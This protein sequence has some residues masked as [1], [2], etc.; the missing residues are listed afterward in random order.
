MA[1]SL[2]VLHVDDDQDFLELLKQLLEK[3][4][5]GISITSVPNPAL[6]LQLLEDGKF[7]AVISDYQMREMT[8]LELLEKLR[9][10]GS[11]IPFIMLTGKGR[12]EIAV[13][14]LKLGADYYLEKGSNS[15]ALF[16]TLE[17]FLLKI[18]EKNMANMVSEV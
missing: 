8:G 18:A 13:Q 3:G 5:A 14:A 11:S 17:H 4:F 6:G 2:A 16:T 9:K 7:D 12:E 10:K 15:K 1:G